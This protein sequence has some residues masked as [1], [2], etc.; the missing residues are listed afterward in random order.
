MALTEVVVREIY[1]NLTPTT[2]YCT[3]KKEATT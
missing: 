2:R 1:T 3:Y